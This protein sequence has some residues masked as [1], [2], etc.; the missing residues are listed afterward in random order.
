MSNAK[1]KKK[2]ESYCLISLQ[3]KQ[4]VGKLINRSDDSGMKLCFEMVVSA[5]LPTNEKFAEAAKTHLL[6][7]DLCHR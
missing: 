1:K 3:V 2:P 6:Y 5:C 7:L 4:C